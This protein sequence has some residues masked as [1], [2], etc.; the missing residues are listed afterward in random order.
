[1]ASRRQLQKLAVGSIK[2]L[3]KFVDFAPM[4]ILMEEGYKY[5]SNDRFQQEESAHYLQTNKF[6]IAH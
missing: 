5:P 6:F 1:M 3:P 2:Y 4:A